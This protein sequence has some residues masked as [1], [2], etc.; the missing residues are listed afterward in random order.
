MSVP[1][2]AMIFDLDGT[3]CEYRI[4]PF[5]ALRLTLSHEGFD[6][7]MTSNRT[8]F[9]PNFF[10]EKLKSVWQEGQDLAQAGQVNAFAYGASTETVRRMLA[11]AGLPQERL[12]PLLD[13]YLATMLDHLSLFQDAARVMRALFG[14]CGLALLTNGPSHL[15]WA[16]ID[17]LG[18][19]PW[20]TEIVVSDDVGVR[21]PDPRI[22]QILLQRL[23][24]SA[25]QTLYVGDT[26]QYDVLG[27]TRAGV[28]SV[29]FNPRAKPP[30]PD[31][32]TPAATIT[33]LEQLLDW[34]PKEDAR[35]HR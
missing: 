27:A 13:T 5:D 28:S 1:L 34:L 30:S 32:P 8:V 9:N 22:F 17:R 12:K 25:A 31:Y 18:I 4:K 19:R 33:H 23:G 24:L 3:L 35:N 21:K 2:K 29:W 11:H 20:F 6:A 14:Q 7:W 26:L 16:K 15:Q 10:S